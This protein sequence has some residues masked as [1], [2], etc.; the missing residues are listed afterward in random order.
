M[1][2]LDVEKLLEAVSPESPCG[3]D[4][5]YDS[6]F[7]ELERAAQG[8]PEQQFG[9]TIVPAEDPDLRKVKE[10]ALD[11]FSRTRDLRVAVYLA[12]GATHTDGL[13]GLADSLEVVQGLLDRYWDDVH[14]RLDPDD[15]HDPT[16]RI[17]TLASLCDPDSMLRPVRESPLVSSRALGRFSLR[18]LRLAEGVLTPTAEEP[19]PDLAGID[20]AFLDCDPD[21]L[22]E[23]AACAGRS[24][25]LLGRIES[26]VA[27]R[28]SPEYG[29]QLE[30]LRHVVQEIER[31]LTDR[32]ARRGMAAPGEAPSEPAAAAGPTPAAGAAAPAAPEAVNSR[33]DVIRSLDRI[34]QY[35]ETHEPSSPVPLLLQR[36]KRL[37]RKDFLA[38]IRDLA[39]DGVTQIENLGGISGEEES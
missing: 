26:A 31:V 16:L 17:N 35:Y 21:E 38:I 3:E 30:P 8:K 34:C 6:A 20:A 23:T 9:D 33:E 14:P 25:E 5:E 32:L 39:P 13:A 7:G 28:V 4:L 24:L 18:D 29:V 12:R 15:N 36:A 37:V 1:R 10:T 19:V 22:Q 2:A 27:D 11:L